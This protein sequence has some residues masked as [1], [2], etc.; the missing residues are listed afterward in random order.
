[1]GGSRRSD[2]VLGERGDA[3]I[4]AD[5]RERG[6]PQE[7]EISSAP[8]GQSAVEIESSMQAQTETQNGRK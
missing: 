7:M 6:E 5:R 8:R 3:E 2:Q 1:M 4:Y